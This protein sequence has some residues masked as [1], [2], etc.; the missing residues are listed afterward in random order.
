MKFVFQIVAL[1]ITML[2]FYGARGLVHGI[3]SST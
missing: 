1:R 3:E 2:S